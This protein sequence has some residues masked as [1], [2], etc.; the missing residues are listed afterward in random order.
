MQLKYLKFFWILCL[1]IPV[2]AAI[3]GGTYIQKLDAEPTTLNPITFADGYAPEVLGYVLSTLLTRDIDTYAW[4]PS[5]AESWKVSKDGKT[6]TFKLRP[7]VKWHDGKPLTAEDI[8]FSF[9]VYFEGKFLAPQK[10]VYLENIQEVRIVDPK[11]VQFIIK[12]VYFKNFD[13]A[14]GLSILPKHFYLNADPKDPKFNREVIGTGPYLLES[15][16]KG[17]K[18]VIKKFKDFFGKSDPDLKNQFNFE[19]IIFKPV[20]EVEVAIEMLKKGNID[21]LDMSPFPDQ[22]MNKMQGPEWGPKGKVSSFKVKNSAVDTFNYGFIAWNN[23]SPFFSDRN[24]RMAMSHLINRDLMNE[25]FRFGMSEKAVGP[26]GNGS[27]SSSPKVKAVAY[28]PKK[29]LQLLQGAGWKLGPN[30]LSKEIDGKEVRFEFTLLAGTNTFE[31]Y[32]T[33]IKEDMAKIGITM[34]IKIVEWNS[35]VKILDER[36]FDAINLA[37]GGGSLEQDPKQIWHSTSMAGTGSNF[38]SYSNPLVDQKIDLLRSSMDEK[39][40]RKY[41]REIH[42]LIMADQPYSFL[43]NRKYTLYGRTNRMG[44][45]RDTFKYGIGTEY[46]WAIPE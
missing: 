32:A 12:N 44:T 36:K 3:Q 29:A 15:W 31:R 17:Q 6:I 33:V 13:V 10:K 19:Q 7:G 30:G 25:K 21:F 40:R 43:F 11:T 42:E 20:K 34:N 45:P 9:D 1:A 14:A 16:E 27:P 24:I 4:K 35:F 22:F 41:F 8:K 38:I 46:W 23:K 37:W 18:I 2:Q 26:W 39:V 28:D 5:L